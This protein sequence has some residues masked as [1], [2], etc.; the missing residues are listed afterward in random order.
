MDE[1]KKWIIKYL[2][3]NSSQKI[4][5]KETSILTKSVLVLTKK[6][7]LAGIFE[8]TAAKGKKHELVIYLQVINSNAFFKLPA[9]IML[10]DGQSDDTKLKGSV[11][12]HVNRF[13]EDGYNIPVMVTR[14]KIAYP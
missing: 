2:T 4:S 9:L 5:D 10:L 6:M 8:P 14:N 12:T 3:D 7:V 11:S 1:L 13:K